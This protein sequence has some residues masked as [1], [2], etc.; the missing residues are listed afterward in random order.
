MKTKLFRDIGY[1]VFILLALGSCVNEMDMVENEQGL[2]EI[3]RAHV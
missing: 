2:E 3:G 1:L